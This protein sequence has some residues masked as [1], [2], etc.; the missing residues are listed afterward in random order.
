MAPWISPLD[1]ADES[2]D[3]ARTRVDESLERELASGGLYAR[4]RVATAFVGRSDDVARAAPDALVVAVGSE[5]ARAIALGVAV[6]S[7]ASAYG[8]VARA[9]ADASSARFGS[10]CGDAL[11]TLRR[12]TIGTMTVVVAETSADATATSAREWAR[13]T[14]RACGVERGSKTRVL[15][16]TACSEH[17]T[18]EAEMSLGELERVAAYGLDTTALRAVGDSAWPPMPRAFPVGVL[19]RSNG[20][21][22]LMTACE[23]LGVAARAV[24]IPE[25]EPVRAMY[26]GADIDAVRE[27]ATQ[28][29]ALLG[30]DVRYEYAPRMA[31]SRAENVYA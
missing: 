12:G 15:A 30:C 9:D 18:S 6:A 11:T 8:V 22:A 2:V 1:L 3:F 17:E 5:A 13:E 31:P 21:A 10:A 16:L 29:S 14:L 27:A 24:A 19:L 4:R 23:A 26:G 28:A 20:A 25:S 7:N